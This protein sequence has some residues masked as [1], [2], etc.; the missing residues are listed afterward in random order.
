MVGGGR[1]GRFGR[2]GGLAL[3]HEAALCQTSLRHDRSL[4]HKGFELVNGLPWLPTDGALH[5]LLAAR[6]LEQAQQLQVGLGQ[7]RWAS[8]HFRGR[9]WALD[10]YRWHGSMTRI[11]NGAVPEAGAPFQIAG[12]MN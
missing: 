6:T 3:V 8:G 11:L 12:E 9:L 7:L 2:A 5:D 1:R 4:R 10:P